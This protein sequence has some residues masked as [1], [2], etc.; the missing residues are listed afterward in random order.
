MTSTSDPRAAAL[1]LVA[2]VLDKRQQL[3]DALGAAFEKGGAYADLDRRDRAFAR[4]LVTTVLRRLGQIDSTIGALLDRPLPARLARVR[5]ALRLGVAQLVFLETPPHAAVDRTVRLVGRKSPFKRL[6]NAVLRR[7]TRERDELIQDQD[8]ARL[9]T[10]DWLW[11][12]W[13]AAYG[14]AKARAIAEAHLS[15]PPLDI[16]V[17]TD[18][19]IWAE[20]L[21]ARV[22]PTGTLRRTSGG[23]V[24]DLPGYADGE[25][26][27]QDV[28]SMVPAR[29]LL[30]SL[31]DGGSGTRILDACAAPG[32]KTA[33]LAAAGAQVEA[34]DVSARRLSTLQE[35]L[36][37]LD[38][39]AEVFQ[40][41]FRDWEP[42]APYQAILLD[43][44]CTATG[45]IR[46]HPDIPRLRRSAD[47]SRLA[48]LQ[49]QLLDAA[50]ETLA[51][52]G[53]LVYCTCSL[54]PEEGAAQIERLLSDRSD[55]TRW[56]IE[57]ALV[58]GIEEALRPNGDV[59]ILPCH[60]ADAGGTDGFFISRLK[61]RA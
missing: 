31:E 53:V 30:S 39:S 43:A 46:R 36:R 23:A 5:N 35:N 16:S 20:R 11:D 61:R 41:D 33:Q 8:A 51:P 15:E 45:T 21:D 54:Q 3:D 12:S 55:L 25:W 26:W 37:R 9:N 10:P 49:A 28:A 18:P 48:K 19:D 17:K 32:G 52:D 27:I 14:E 59:Q 4:L 7:L 57:K 6:V 40:R 50:A 47:V 44:P 2:A 56:P 38:L 42:P 58:P 13:C 24:G 22:L 1:D 29:V 60:L 34:L